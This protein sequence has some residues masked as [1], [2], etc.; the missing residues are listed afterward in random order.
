MNTRRRHRFFAARVAAR[1]VAPTSGQ[2]I[3]SSHQPDSG[4]C[5]L[6]QPAPIAALARGKNVS[7]IGENLPDEMGCRPEST[8]QR[9]AETTKWRGSEHNAQLPSHI[10]NTWTGCRVAELHTGRID[11]TR[12]KPRARRHDSTRRKNLTRHSCTQ[13]PCVRRPLIPQPVRI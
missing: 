10:R 12:T 7:K 8:A 9:P 1:V 11:T 6:P 2:T 4:Q 5:T 13:R 3:P